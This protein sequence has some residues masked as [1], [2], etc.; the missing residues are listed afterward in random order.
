MDTLSSFTSAGWITEHNLGTTIGITKQI[1]KITVIEWDKQEQE[2]LQEQNES[3]STN[4]NLFQS[5]WWI[6]PCL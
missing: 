5:I 1:L 6:W 4:I 3:I 2:V